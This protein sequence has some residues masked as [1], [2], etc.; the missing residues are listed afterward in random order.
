M[1][2]IKTLGDKFTVEEYGA[3]AYWMNWLY[4]Y[5][6]NIPKAIFLPAVTTDQLE[7]LWEQEEFQR[8]MKSLLQTKMGKCEWFAIRSSA[9]EEDS[10]IFSKAGYYESVLNVKKTTIYKA[11]KQVVEGAGGD[12][13]GVIVQEMISSTSGGVVFSANPLNAS[14]EELLV[15]M[16]NGHSHNRLLGGERKGESIIL[17]KSGFLYFPD[18]HVKIDKRHLRKLRLII[19]KIEKKQGRPV[20]VEWCVSRKYNR[21]Y[22]LQC[23]PVTGLLPL[24]NDI[25]KINQRLHGMIPFYLAENDKIRIR[26]EAQKKNIFISDAYL[27]VCSCQSEEFPITKLDIPRSENCRGYSVVLTFPSRLDNKILRSFVGSNKNSTKLLNDSHSRVI[28]LKKSR[29]ED[30][31]ECLRDYYNHVK[32]KYWTFAAIIQ[33]IFDPLYT[34]NFCQMKDKYVIEIGKGHFMSKGTKPMTKYICDLEG[35][36]QFS[37][38]VSIDRYNG[39]IEGNIVEYLNDSLERVYID[40]NDIKK[41]IA[42]FNGLVKEKVIIEFGIL[43]NA[44][45][46]PYL[47]D[48]TREEKE[49]TITPEEIR[50]GIISRGRR[51]GNIAK[52]RSGAEWEAFD[53]HYLNQIFIRQEKSDIK[54][55][56]YADSPS[57]EF[58]RILEE[59]EADDIAF[60]FREG[61]VLCHFS[62]LLR[63]KGVPAIVGIQPD[64]IKE[65]EK[66]MLDTEKSWKLR[67]I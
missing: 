56:F 20:D 57:I 53:I 19:T 38:E 44:A 4:Q 22:F 7:D 49:R 35:N 21:L 36:I 3:K 62:V 40:A 67:K 51:E 24:K 65:N 17:N 47:I 42:E 58:T 60:V 5:K 46:R 63:E 43:N 23:R 37:K 11:I 8:E 10:L 54:Y 18:Y 59:Y 14:R 55:I 39:I 32:K 1:G 15:S 30:L 29:Y 25:N 13:I 61:S 45:R 52:L 28:V 2:I 27:A 66:Y 9:P 64:D 6:V 41:I 12:R 48:Y 16:I 26:L 31:L 34:G 50:A 33:E